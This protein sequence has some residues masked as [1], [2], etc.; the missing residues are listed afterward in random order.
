MTTFGEINGP[1]VGIVMKEAVRRAIVAI[2]RN[3]FLFE[4]QEKTGYS[5]P[6]DLVTTVDR[7]AQE[8]YVRTIRKCF[9]FYGVVAEEGELI[10]ECRMKGV[11]IYF[12]IDPLDGT[13]AFVRR[14]S[15]GIGTMIS[16]VVNGEI[17]AAFVG[18]VMTQEIFG[19]RPESENVRRISEYDYAEKLVI[20]PERFLGSQYVLLRDHAR[21]YSPLVRQM[22]MPLEEGGLFKSLEVAGGSIG[23]SAARLWKGEVGALVFSPGH[24]TPWDL[25]PVLGISRK[26]GF[27]FLRNDDGEWLRYGPP[28]SGTVERRSHEVLVIHKSRLPELTGWERQFALLRLCSD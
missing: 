24:D 7:A 4:V 16:L 27:V 26:L 9:P 6:H 17:I 15:H 12:T 3:R 14:Q 1:I 25:Y 19:F 11:N 20:D 8:I 10:I 2:R 21:S 18:D 5:D 22:L 28:L 13:K 23:I